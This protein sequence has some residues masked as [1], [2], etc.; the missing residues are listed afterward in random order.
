V[1]LRDIARAGDPQPL[2]SALTEHGVLVFRDQTLTPDELMAVSRLLGD[3]E[4]HVLDQFRMP[5]RP[6]IYVL[7]NIVENGRPVG[8]PKDGFGWHT[9]QAYIARP[10]AYTLLYG[11]ETP[12]EGA[13]T[14]FCSTFAALEALLPARRAEISGLR[15]IHS[16]AYMHELRR[17]ELPPLTEEQTRRTPDVTHPLVRRHPISGRHSL[18]VGGG[19]VAGVVGMPDVP[20][21]AMMKE[22]FTHATQPQ[23]RY[24]HKW[25]PRDLVVWDNRGTMHTATEY[26]R[27]KYRR[28]IWRTSLIGEVPVGPAA[29]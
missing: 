12:A 2:I 22:L 7:S 9:D 8:N 23:F 28:L 19:A 16:L 21:R 5:E 17:H 4:R 1:D 25:Q 24:V 26:D 3:F 18:Y 29:G 20:A 10:T 13:D 11:V 15:V 6:D 14:L 27:T